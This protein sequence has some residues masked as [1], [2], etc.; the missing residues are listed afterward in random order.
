VQIP[1]LS[2]QQTITSNRECERRRLPKDH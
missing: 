1:A 2:F